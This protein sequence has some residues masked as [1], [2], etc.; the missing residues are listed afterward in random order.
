MDKLKK[1][2]TL[3]KTN[4]KTIIL[5]VW[6]SFI[7]YVIIYDSLYP[8]A[9]YRISRALDDTEM[10]ISEGVYSSSH[11]VMMHINRFD[12]QINSKMDAIESEVN[13][14]KSDVSS[15]KNQIT[16]KY[17]FDSLRSIIENIDRKIK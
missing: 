12:R 10:N 3:V 7:T 16:S 9:S 1:L 2:F 5:V 8:T 15:I 13:N 14:I 4:W 6:M 11:E 17:G